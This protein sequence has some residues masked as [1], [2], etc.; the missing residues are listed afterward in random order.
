MGDYADISSRPRIGPMDNSDQLRCASCGTA[1]ARDVTAAGVVGTDGQNVPFR[2][3]TDY[4]VCSCLASY[5]VTDLRA[6]IS[7]VEARMRSNT[8]S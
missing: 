3:H 2:R 6:V 4:V 1:L 8:A 7:H 5:R